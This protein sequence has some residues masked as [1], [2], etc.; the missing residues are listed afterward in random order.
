MSTPLETQPA[1]R[2][3]SAVDLFCMQTYQST[4]GPSAEVGPVD[5]AALARLASSRAEES[6]SAAVGDM[7]FSMA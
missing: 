4:R 1:A 7:E 5:L 6:G 3:L 2:R